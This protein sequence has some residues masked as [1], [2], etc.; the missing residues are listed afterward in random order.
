MKRPEP[1]D[2]ASLSASQVQWVTAVCNEF[3]EDWGRADRPSVQEYMNRVGDDADAK[4]RLVLLR[5]LLTSELELLEQDAQTRQAYAYRAFFSDPDE[6]DVVDFVHPAETNGLGAR[7][8]HVVKRHAQGGLGEVFIAHDRHVDRDVALKKIKPELADDQASRN[9]FI[10]EAEITGQL[11]HP[12]IAPVYSLGL[13]GDR[14]PF[15]A[16][17][18]IQGQPLHEAIA[19]LHKARGARGNQGERSL[20]L[21]KLLGRFNA[22]CDAAAFAHS[23]GILHRDIKP[24]NVILGRFGETILVDWG[25]AKKVGAS[26]SDFLP[27]AVVHGELDGTRMTEQGSVLG[28]LPYMSPEQAESATGPLGAASDIYSLGATLYHLLTGRPAF[29]GKDY[30]K[31]RRNVIQGEFPSP[32]QIDPQVPRALEAIVKK[33]MAREPA[34]RYKTATALAEDIEH[35]LADELVSAWREPLLVRTGRGIRRHRALVQ[36]AAAAVVVG[37]IGLAGFSG[38]L[39][40]KN[41]ELDSERQQ[42]VEQ[43]NRAE[44]ARDHAFSAVKAIVETDNDQMRSEELR[45]YR[46]KL[47]DEGIRLSREMIDGTEGDERAEKLQAQAL[48][49]EANML[50]EKGDR[51]RASAVGKQAVEILERLVAHD[52]ADTDNRDA[53]ARLLQNH[54]I[55]GASTET[56]RS[57]SLRSI[58]IFEALLRENPRS[59]QAPVWIRAIGLNF[60]NIGNEYFFDSESASGEKRLDLLSKAIDEFRA[61]R[62]FCED[63]VKAIDRRDKVLFSLALNARY[64]CRAY[65]RQAMLLADAHRRSKTFAEAIAW[66]RMAIA[67]F[68]ALANEDM[69]HYQNSFDLH[70]AQLELGI[71]F[72]D[73]SKWDEA[74]ECYMEARETLKRMRQ[75]HGTL[76]SRI[77]QIETLIAVDDHNLVMALM[78]NAAANE[79]LIRELVDEAY[80]ICE[81]LDARGQLSNQLPNVYAYVSFLKADDIESS[82]GQPDI[83]LS[84]KAARLYQRLLDQNPADYVARCYSLLTRLNLAD[85]LAAQGRNDESRTIENDAMAA[86]KEF[87]DVF[88]QTAYTYAANSNETMRDPNEGE[89]ATS[90][91][92]RKRYARRVIPLLRA[93]AASGF[94]DVARLRSDQA[95]N[96]YRA[97]P[98]FQAIE[99]DVAFPRD[100]FGPSESKAQNR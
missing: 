1:P 90:A 30:E 53:L 88:F 100:A 17:R 81:S 45:P 83:N 19:D 66:G 41:R 97:D 27:D 61:G 10:R 78:S 73:Q 11:E 57:N 13:D 35:W 94:K 14:L 21:R 75:R 24:A 71:V 22:V 60:H 49:M 3:E 18:F 96:P 44:R 63:H 4:V 26:D 46:E 34:G 69:G 32:R 47:L 7:R 85:A 29:A 50:V 65:H 33:A 98:E 64:L 92:L 87:P 31:V 23:R 25:L 55:M 84:R 56:N 20:A 5:E 2:L 52:P 6:Q 59:Q 36:T 89:N 82:T 58:K 38:V 16:M 67:D 15:Y 8:F 77:M 76:A 79:K 70:E 48:M 9:R 40:G 51:S 72:Y 80:A 37:V 99:Q 68:Q 95:F 74:N 42:A 28:T 62:V 86:A 93:A 91:K 43:R 12:N 54:A 39:A